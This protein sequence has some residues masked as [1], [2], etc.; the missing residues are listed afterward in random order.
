MALYNVL[1][2]TPSV[3]TNYLPTL[4]TLPVLIYVLPCLLTL[5]LS[6]AKYGFMIFTTQTH[7][8]SLL[9]LE[10]PIWTRTHHAH[11]AARREREPPTN[12]WGGLGV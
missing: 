10:L 1:T 4:H 3:F 8:Y 11:G 6:P 12:G 9:T 2:L 5:D 7:I